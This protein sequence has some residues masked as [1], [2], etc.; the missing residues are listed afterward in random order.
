MPRPQPVHI[1]VIELGQIHRI[2]DDNP[3]GHQPEQAG[4][5]QHQDD[6]SAPANDN[7]D[8]PAIRREPANR[9]PWPVGVRK[10]QPLVRWDAIGLERET[11][12]IAHARA[13]GVNEQWRDDG[14]P[15]RGDA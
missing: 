11:K 3:L 6:A 2:S 10:C 13:G 9:P 8:R 14:R 12:Q 4:P 7:A 1:H 5:W 15:E